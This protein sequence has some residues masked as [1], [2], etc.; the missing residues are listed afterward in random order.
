MMMRL[1]VAIDLPEA[2]KNNLAD[3][4]FGLSGARWVPLHQQHLTV[5]FIGEVDEPL[6]HD[7]C[8]ELE[9]VEIER[10]GITLKGVGHFPPRKVHGVLWVG[11]EK[12]DSLLGLRKK[13]DSALAGCSI[14]SEKR[15]FSPHI[16]LARL[17]KIPP[18]QVTQFLDDNALFSLPEFTV[19]KFYLYSSVL[20]PKGAVHRVEAEYRL[21]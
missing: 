9:Q 5:R 2:I 20:T 4:S 8:S 10:F 19:R 11:L 18:Q 16:T 15:Q 13:V 3:I 1:F 17:K 14:I 12:S 21:L 6:F 7:I